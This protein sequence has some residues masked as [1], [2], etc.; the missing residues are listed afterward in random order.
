[1]NQTSSTAGMETECMNIDPSVLVGNSMREK[2]SLWQEKYE[3][4]KE[5][6]AAAIPLK[7]TAKVTDDCFYF[8]DEDELRGKSNE[9]DELEENEQTVPRDSDPL[10]GLAYDIDT[11]FYHPGDML[12]IG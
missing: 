8:N 9:E 7:D 10:E 1:M 2:L 3:S 5:L 12:E 4:G 6:A 11:L